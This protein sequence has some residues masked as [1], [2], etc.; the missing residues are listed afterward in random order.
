MPIP[1]SIDWEIPTTNVDGTPIAPGEIT[2]Y[3]IGIRK[4]SDPQPAQ[5]GTGT[6]PVSFLVTNPALTHEAFS[7]V[8]GNLPQD[9]YKITMQTLSTTNGNGPFAPEKDFSTIIPPK[10]NAPGFTV[11]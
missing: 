10:P 9:N 4:A 8:G 3:L 6:Y 2:G 11:S 1:T 7:V 5:D